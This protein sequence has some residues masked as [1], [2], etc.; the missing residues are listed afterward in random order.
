MAE[1]GVEELRCRAE[2]EVERNSHAAWEVVV[3]GVR[4]EEGACWLLLDSTASAVNEL[5]LDQVR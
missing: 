2:E 1:E 4:E 5:D 3:V